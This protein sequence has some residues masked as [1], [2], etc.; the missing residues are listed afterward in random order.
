MTSSTFNQLCQAQLIA[1]TVA[2]EDA[3]IVQA[4]KDADDELVADL[5][6]TKF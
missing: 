4:L 6:V 2:L 5:I 3:E 1:P